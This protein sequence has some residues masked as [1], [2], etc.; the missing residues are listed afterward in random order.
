MDASGPLPTSAPPQALHS[1]E[2]ISANFA[3]CDRCSSKIKGARYKCLAC[4]DFDYC[5]VCYSDASLIHPG[6]DFMALNVLSTPHDLHIRNEPELHVHD[7][8]AR[9][10]LSPPPA[11][12][13]CRS[14]EP[15][16]KPLPAI[17]FLLDDPRL[18]SEVREPLREISLLWAVRISSLVEATQRGC[19]FCAFIMDRFFFS[20]SLHFY[21]YSP[22][23]PWYA[24]PL[25]HDDQ[26]QSAV[27]HCMSIL[28]RFGDG[29]IMFL[30]T[31]S[32]RRLGIVLPDFDRLIIGVDQKRNNL[33]LLRKANVFMLVG[34][35]EI[36]VDI[37]AAKGLC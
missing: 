32:C 13:L 36:E 3:T 21:G 29:K 33:D 34:K 6:H 28:T 24:Q 4:P 10:H 18:K 9:L 16:T 23:T 30:V 11:H 17:H 27:A 37:Y 26:R 14:C 20:G 22:A 5:S 19:A 8:I 12:R 25:K 2:E 31:P 7:D 1:G 15:I 35:L